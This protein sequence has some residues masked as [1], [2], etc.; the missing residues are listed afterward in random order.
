MGYMAASFTTA[1]ATL[2]DTRGASHAALSGTI[3]ANNEKQANSFV[4]GML[5]SVYPFN[6]SGFW[7]SRSCQS[8]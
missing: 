2:C 7:C 1:T 8:G 6:M 3:D 4:K 5:A